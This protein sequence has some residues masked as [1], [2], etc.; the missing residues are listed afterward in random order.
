MAHFELAPGEISRA[1]A[2][3]SVEEIWLILS[4]K[5]ELWR[6]QVARE[7]VVALEP[8]VC[9]SLPHGTH[10][11]FRASTL[12]PV[13]LVAVTIP[14]WP[15]DGEAELVHGPWETSLKQKP[16]QGGA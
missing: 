15:G 11:Q 13:T 5:G 16:K 12:E 8:G 9:I 3:R 7:E 1:I 14:R 10:F 4:G 2:H 6:K